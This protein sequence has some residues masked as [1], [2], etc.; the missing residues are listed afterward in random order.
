MPVGIGGD[1]FGAI[2]LEAASPTITGNLFRDSLWYAISADVGSFPAVSGNELTKNGGNGLEV[3]SG[4]M[5][6]ANTWS[7]KDI[8]YVLTGPVTVRNT[9]TLNIEPGVTVKFADSTYIDVHG[10]FKAVGTANQRIVFT[11]LRD[12]SSGGDTNGDGRSSTAAAGD[13]T[14]IRFYDDSNDSSCIIDHATIRYA[15][16]LSRGPLRRDPCP[17]RLTGGQEQQHQQRL[18]MRGLVRQGLVASPGRKHLRRQRGWECLP[19]KVNE[20]NQ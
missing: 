13:W 20:G 14:M 12:D 17:E 5:S 15:G 16:R 6:S 18:C 10:A 7:N 19:G 4:E 2:H 9:A 8:V 1:R 11:S 3:R